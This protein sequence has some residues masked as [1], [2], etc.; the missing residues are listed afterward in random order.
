MICRRP[1]ITLPLHTKLLSHYLGSE[2]DLFFIVQNVQLAAQKTHESGQRES[3]SSWENCPFV[4]SHLTRLHFFPFLFCSI[5]GEA[6]ER[7]VL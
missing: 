4:Y 1:A 6:S 3:R 7:V 2:D 5:N